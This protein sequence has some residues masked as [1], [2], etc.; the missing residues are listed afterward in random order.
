MSCTLYSAFCFGYNKQCPRNNRKQPDG[1][2]NDLKQVNKKKPQQDWHGKGGGSERHISNIK[3]DLTESPG[4]L[5]EDFW[6]K[7]INRCPKTPIDNL[8]DL[9]LNRTPL[10]RGGLDRMPD[11]GT[12]HRP[13]TWDS[14]WTVAF[15]KQQE[16]FVF[17][18]WKLTIMWS[19]LLNSYLGYNFLDIFQIKS[20]VLTLEMSWIRA[21]P[22]NF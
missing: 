11:A 7:R 16:V 18:H 8:N 12:D 2:G 14:S 5:T 15:N 19:Q 1:P 10:E 21:G 4:H 17:F 9:A 13:E 3:R 22:V 20:Q 6:N